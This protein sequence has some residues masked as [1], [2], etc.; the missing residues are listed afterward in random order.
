VA[1]SRHAAADAGPRDL[2]TKAAADRWLSHKR[3]DLERGNS[4]DDRAAGRPLADW[5]PGYLTFIQARCR[6]DA[7]Q[8]RYCSRQQLAATP[9][10]LVFP[11]RSGGLR[12]HRTFRRDSWDPAARAAGLTVTPHDL[13][14]TCASLLIDA[15]ASIKDVQAQLGHQDPIT[16][17]ALYARVRPGRA[18][19]LA[20]KMDAPIAELSQP[21]SGHRSLQ[22]PCRRAALPHRSWRFVA[23]RPTHG[24]T[25]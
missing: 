19:V 15:G 17:L 1:Q 3:V 24:S 11:N 21:S 25:T 23:A 5:W 16:T 12:R 10:E 14:A 2:P 13:P 18:D 22:G 8:P 20:D 7:H 9:G 6:D 4:L